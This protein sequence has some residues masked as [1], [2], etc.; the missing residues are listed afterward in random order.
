MSKK[1]E[2]RNLANVRLSL[3]K[4]S[5]I[6]KPFAMWTNGPVAVSLSKKNGSFDQGNALQEYFPIRF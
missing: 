4:E 5:H 6:I 3:W 1:Y 2:E